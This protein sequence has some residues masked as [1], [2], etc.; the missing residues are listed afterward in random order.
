MNFESKQ[1]SSSPADRA[2]ERYGVIFAN[3]DEFIKAA[4]AFGRAVGQRLR[5]SNA[6]RYPE[7]YFHVVL[8]LM[9]NNSA[10][11][12]FSS[13]PLKDFDDVRHLLDLIVLQEPLLNVTY[14]KTPEGT[15]IIYSNAN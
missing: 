7:V 5:Q 15:R 12:L 2:V 11:L 1:P 6:S 13:L 10:S 14:E 4:A 9:S 8:G 3:K